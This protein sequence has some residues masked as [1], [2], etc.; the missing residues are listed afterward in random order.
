DM[1][2]RKEW[3]DACGQ[4]KLAKDP[5]L[6]SLHFSPKAFE[7]FSRPQLL[8][9]LTNGRDKKHYIPSWQD[10]NMPTLVMTPQGLK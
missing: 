1:K 4:I 7:A 9:E 3:E 5:R 6:C 2:R 8:K 10:V